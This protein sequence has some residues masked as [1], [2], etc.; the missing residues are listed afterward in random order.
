MSKK[1]SIDSVRG[2]R[3]V[4]RRLGAL[5][6]FGLVPGLAGM[7]SRNAYA[8]GP[9]K[10]LVC[11][12]LFGGNDG[13]NLVVPTDTAGYGDYLLARGNAIGTPANGAL[14]LPAAGAT[15][16]V[17]PL[18]GINFGLHPSMPEL[19]AL[20]NSGNVALLF[21]AGALVRPI[22]VAQ[23]QAGLT[24]P[25]LV[26]ENL[27]SHVDQQHQMQMTSVPG[28]GTTGWAGRIADQVGGS[29]TQI[30]VGVS[31][32]GNVLFLAGNSAVPIVVPESGPLAYSGLSGSAAA[33][34][35]LAA[36]QSL[37]VSGAA[38]GSLAAAMGSIQTQAIATANV[39]SPVLSG[40]SA[41]ASHFPATGGTMSALSQQLLQVARLVQAASTGA[42]SAPAQQIFFVALGGFD[43]HNDQ[44]NRQAPLL[45]DLS[46]SL[47]GFYNAMVTLGM[48]DAVTTFTLSDFARTLKPASG[49]GSDHAWGSHHLVLGG[50]GSVKAGAY[51]TFPDLVLGG[52]SDVSA[53]G[54]W[55]PGISID[56]Y[57]ATLGKWFG[58]TPA[59]LAVAFPNLANFP[60]QDLGFLA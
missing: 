20:W 31:A 23:Y 1:S 59:Q 24:N 30:P 21:N 38:E 50:A 13:N 8:A 15:G 37:F 60:V 45:A 41:L 33:S 29:A 26:P 58:L 47:A 35:R 34:A 48:Q 46:S 2:R 19:Q 44:L 55:L 17:L 43:T 36:L 52:A 12:F 53:Q 40:S 22:T 18:N 11:V 57:G 39:L 7:V 10:A 3:D 14:A 27:F 25:A 4:L 16:G 32:A 6:A 51:G 49:G 42:I 54:R 9:Y 56:Q 5:S 28:L